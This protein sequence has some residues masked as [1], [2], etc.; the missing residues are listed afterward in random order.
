MAR[1]AR[2]YKAEYARRVASAERRGL[3]RTQAR[4]HPREGE[5]SAQAIRDATRTI[6]NVYERRGLNVS[7]QDFQGAMQ[8]FEQDTR[9]RL[10]TDYFDA[11]A[12]ELAE[13]MGVERRYAYSV[14]LGSP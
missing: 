7:D 3:S 6:A 13:L 1:R 14:L 2:D 9:F 4:G 5:P 11:R 12:A 10:G 8:V